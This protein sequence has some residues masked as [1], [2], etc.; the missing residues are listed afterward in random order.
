M[1]DVQFAMFELHR[2]QVLVIQIWR[3]QNRTII[4]KKNHLHHS[5]PLT[6]WYHTNWHWSHKSK[7]TLKTSTFCDNTL[8]VYIFILFSCYM[9]EEF[10]RNKNAFQWDAYRPLVDCIPACTGKGVC[11]PAC[12]RQGGVCPGGV[13]LGVC[14]RHPPPGTKGRPPC[15][16]TDTRENIIFA[17]FVCGR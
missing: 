17:N 14:G 6:F 7:S 4:W 15:G 13:C 8:F 1:T 10:K 5:T 3:T 16:Q 11:I 9:K 2:I 12:T